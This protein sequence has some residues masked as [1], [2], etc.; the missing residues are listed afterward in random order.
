MLL[1]SKTTLYWHL[2]HRLRVTFRE[3]A[4]YPKRSILLTL[5][6]F[7]SLTALITILLCTFV[8]LYLLHESTMIK[9]NDEDHRIFVFCILCALMASDVVISSLIMYSFVNGLRQLVVDMKATV[10]VDGHDAQQFHDSLVN[11]DN[12]ADACDSFDQ[13]MDR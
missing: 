8:T 5:N 6:L 4:Y 3:S 7:M 2:I 12:Y 9:S 1:I 10:M 11:D 13:M